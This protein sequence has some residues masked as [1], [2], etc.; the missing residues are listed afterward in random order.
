[1]EGGITRS[2]AVM[3][4]SVPI[5]GVFFRM[6]QRFWNVKTVRQIRILCQAVVL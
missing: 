3:R 6:F 1:M 4:H 5:H 2:D